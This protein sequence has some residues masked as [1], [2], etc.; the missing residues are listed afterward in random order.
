[1]GERPGN[2]ALHRLL[3]PRAWCSTRESF[4]DPEV[5]LLPTGSPPETDPGSGPAC[6]TWAHPRCAGWIPPVSGH[7]LRAAVHDLADLSTST[8]FASWS[9][10]RVS[11]VSTGASSVW[12]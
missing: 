8:S 7:D 11:M 3:A 6:L 2:S 9:T 12:S 5:N 10:R 1:H 4:A